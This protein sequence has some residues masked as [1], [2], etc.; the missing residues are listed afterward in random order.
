ELESDDGASGGARRGHLVQPREL[1][2]LPFE[3][4]RHRGGHDLG[5]RAGVE[6]HDLD[7]RVVDLRQRGDGE[8]LEPDRSGDEQPGHQERG[9]DRPEDEGARRAHALRRR[10]GYARSLRPAG[11]PASDSARCGLHRPPGPP[12][13][14]PPPLPRREA[15]PSGY[16]GDSSRRD[17]GIAQGYSD[18]LLTLLAGGALARS[19]AGTAAA[20]RG[21]SA[22]RAD[23]DLRPGLELVHALDDDDFSGGNAL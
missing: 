6:G 4:G 16:S 21:G 10:S 19:F 3:G 11:A 12:P 15:P 9:R 8:L 7:R 13:R 23:G 22:G 17:R 1:S 5:R 14:L 2:E 18:T 20:A